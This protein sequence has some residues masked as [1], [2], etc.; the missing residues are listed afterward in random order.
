MYAA[1][2]IFPSPPE[3]NCSHH[4]SLCNMGEGLPVRAFMQATDWLP[5]HVKDTH[6]DGSGPPSATTS[7]AYE[8]KS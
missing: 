4:M 6:P 8:L 1:F 3:Y 5:F 2:E 7:L